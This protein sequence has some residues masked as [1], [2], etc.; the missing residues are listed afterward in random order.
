MRW[1]LQG[2]WRSRPFDRVMRG[3]GGRSPSRKARTVSSLGPLG[4]PEA[5][6][7]VPLPEE[8]PKWG[9]LD[10]YTKEHSAEYQSQA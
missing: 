2:R 10:T 6:Y 4:G 3:E 5:E 8:A 1:L 7:M 9:I